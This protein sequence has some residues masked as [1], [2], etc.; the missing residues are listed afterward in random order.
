[1]VS[2]DTSRVAGGDP[3]MWTDIVEQNRDAIL[4]QLKF[5]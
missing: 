2:W 1:M 3:G 4:H 5:P